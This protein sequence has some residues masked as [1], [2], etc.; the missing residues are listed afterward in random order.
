VAPVDL[1]E[2]ADH[3]SGC[4]WPLAAAGSAVL[5]ACL[6]VLLA[7]RKSLA[8]DE[9]DAV[10]VAR[11]SLPDLLDYVAGSET[12]RAVQLVVLQPV[13]RLSDAEWAVRAPSAAAFVLAVVLAYPLGTRLFGRLAGLTSA[14]AVATCAGA[15]AAAQQ[16]R[17]YAFALAGIML[18]SLLFVRALERSSTGRWTAY[19]L[20]AA[21]LPLLHPAAAAAL[22]A[23]A[24]AA[25][26]DSRREPRRLVAFAAALAVALLLVVVTILDRRNAPDGA[27]RLDIRDVAEGAAHGVGWNV[28][29]VAA[30]TAGIGLVAAGRVRGAGTWQ[31]VLAGG[32]ALAPILLLLL[33]ALWL[34]VYAD[35]VL[36]LST[37][38][39][40]LGA[41]ALVA[42]LPARWATAAA[43][44]LTAAAAGTLLL[45]YASAPEENWRAAARAVARSRGERESVVV[46]PERAR[47]VLG[48]YAPGVPTRPR[49][50][51]QGAWVLVHAPDDVE[52]IRLARTA[53]RTPRY[54]LAEQTTY[55][56]DVRVQH[57][58]Q[59]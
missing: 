4:L 52:A 35:R 25:A 13:V 11:S 8:V 23:H 19:A 41:G 2:R 59:P 16:A 1:S 47:A 17:P 14:L 53:V 55:G 34:P 30:A 29:L 12:G 44:G 40:A 49:A 26:V 33:A 51:G 28:A 38:G 46:V 48:Y 5:A 50:S 54:A 22:G 20:S 21:A 43:V 7:G 6:G 57:W 37:P 32:L 24:T 31:A 15:V 58:V 56:E 18:S 36:V 27:G 39:L 3:R 45:W 42:A 9:A 10:A